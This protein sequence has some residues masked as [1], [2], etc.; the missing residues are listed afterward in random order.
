MVGT[1]R[2][3]QQIASLHRVRLSA[4]VQERTAFRAVDQKIVVM[5]FPMHV[6]ADGA[7]VVAERQRIEIP[8]KWMARE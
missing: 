4:Y 2:Q 1:G 6:M 8:G 5:V 7:P 3:K